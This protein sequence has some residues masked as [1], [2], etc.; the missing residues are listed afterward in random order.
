MLNSSCCLHIHMTVFTPACKK[1]HLHNAQWF[2]KMWQFVLLS[3][4][5]AW[6]F[7]RLFVSGL[8]SIFNWISVCVTVLLSVINDISYQG[9]L[10]PCVCHD[11]YVDWPASSMWHNFCL[12]RLWLMRQVGQGQD[13]DIW[14]PLWMCQRERL[15]HLNKPVTTTLLWSLTYSFIN[16]RG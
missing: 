2:P 9:S 4:Y 11:W 12:I 6:M 10:Q 7:H 1:Y 14:P 16:G 8:F 13:H 3:S 15:M 5:M